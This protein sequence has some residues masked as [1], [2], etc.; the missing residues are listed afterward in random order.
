VSA[1][2]PAAYYGYITVTGDGCMSRHSR[3]LKFDLDNILTA[4]GIKSSE[5]VDSAK[6]KYEIHSLSR[7]RDQELRDI[8]ASVYKMFLH[9]KFDQDRLFEKC[10]RIV[11]IDRQIGLRKEEIEHVHKSAHRDFK[12]TM[13]GK[14]ERLERDRKGRHG[15]EMISIDS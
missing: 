14:H 11:D 7:Q 2:L 9:K 1:S 12:M 5:F 3:K 8:G 10:G 15:Q 6:I 4:I 13:E